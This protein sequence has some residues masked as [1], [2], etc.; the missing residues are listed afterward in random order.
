MV[1]VFA[2]AEKDL[3]WSEQHRLGLEMALLKAIET[4]KQLAYATPEADTPHAY[5]F[6]TMTTRLFLLDRRRFRSAIGALQ[7]RRPPALRNTV[8]ALVEG[9]PPADLPD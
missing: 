4:G 3:R 8:K 9:N 5:R 6:D 2:A 7:P 1:E